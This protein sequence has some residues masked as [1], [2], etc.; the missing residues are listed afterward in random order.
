[1]RDSVLSNE[2]CGDTINRNQGTVVRRCSQG[3]AKD[4]DE[5]QSPQPV[6]LARVEGQGRKTAGLLAGL[7]L[8]SHVSGDRTMVLRGR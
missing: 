3:A 6:G 2:K 1:M 7:H 8:A 4:K 5:F